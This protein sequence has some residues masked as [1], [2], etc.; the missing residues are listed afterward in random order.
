MPVAKKY[1]E[2]L[3]R[4]IDLVAKRLP[5]R[6]EIVQMLWGGGTSHVL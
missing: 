6:R 2:Y 3:L 4:E 1:L 5:N